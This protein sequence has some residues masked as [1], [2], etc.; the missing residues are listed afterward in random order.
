MS[1]EGLE[2]LR[3]EYE[4]KGLDVADLDADPVAQFRHWFTEVRSAGYY[5][6]NAMVLATVDDAGW[7][8]CRTVL[9][10][11]FD[12]RGFSFFTNYTSAK[13]RELEARARAALTFSW[14]EVRRQV[15]VLGTVRRVDEAESDA[16]F[17]TRPRG[18][19]LGAWASNQ[20]EV[21]ASREV[22]DRRYEELD[23][24]FAGRDVPRPAHWGGYRVRP[25]VVELWQGRANR[26]HDRL[27]YTLE[28]ETTWRI[29]R[30]AP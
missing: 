9:L 30:I 15:R 8:S 11:G 14:P 25:L 6:P 18:S 12:H 4:G 20:S 16:Y 22:L 19:Q 26:L 2:Q 17:A 28:D 27:R 21:V 24:E 7:P 1:A 29:E 13:G 10:K 3:R 5:E 23:R